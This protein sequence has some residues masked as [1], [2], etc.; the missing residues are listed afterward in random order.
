M[1]DTLADVAW[2]M[3]LLPTP[4]GRDAKGL[5][6]RG[7]PDNLNEIVQLLPTPTG[8]DGHGSRSLTANRTN[9]LPTTSIGTTLTDAAW[10]VGGL[11]GLRST[12]GNTPPENEHPTLWS[13]GD[14]TPTSP[15]G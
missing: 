13:T 2:R 5:T 11:T 15:A 6:I 7:N 14:S 10:I 3:A 1:S 4:V 12:D 8:M 9:K